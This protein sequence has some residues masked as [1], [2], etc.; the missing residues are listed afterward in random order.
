MVAETVGASQLF[1]VCC[2][3]PVHP[4]S[5]LCVL[6]PCNVSLQRVP[7]QEIFCLGLLVP[8]TRISLGIYYPLGVSVAMIHWVRE[9]K[10]R[11]LASRW[12]KL[13]ELTDAAELLWAQGTGLHLESYYFVASCPSLL[14]PYGLLEALPKW[15]T[16]KPAFLSG[17]ASGG[18]WLRWIR[19]DGH[20]M[21]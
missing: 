6:L 17:S 3:G 14:C 8:L 9:G 4:S 20:V 11:S 16:C 19:D 12:D 2:P 13:G 15:I 10:P 18:T 21:K 7:F 5:R 1:Q